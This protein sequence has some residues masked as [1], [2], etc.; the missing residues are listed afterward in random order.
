MIVRGAFNHLLRPGLRKDFRDEYQAYAEEY[1]RIL[2]TGS[3]DRAEIEAVTMAGLPRMTRRGEAEP[4]SYIDPVL[5]DK[6]IFVDDEFALGFSVS[7]RTMEDDLYSKAKQNAKWLGRSARLTQEYRCAD[8]LDD[9]FDGNLF[10]GLNGDSLIA[11]DHFLLNAAGT[12]SNRV[13]GDPQLSVTGLQAMFELGEKLVDQNGDPVVSQIDTL[14][15]NIQ[16]EWA[17]IHLTQSELEPY[18]ADNQ[19]NATRRK[20]QNLSY[21]V[22]HYKSQ[23]GRDWFGRDSNLHDAHFLFRVRPEFMDDFDFDTLQAKFIGRQRINVYFFDQ[24][25]WFGSNAA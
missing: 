15:I 8:L 14:V 9:A 16:D 18:T 17:A 4:V 23:D 3:Q 11:D 2:R 22:S 5:S 24:R 10:T 25:G 7:K 19:V 13:A 21:I 20:R 6:F 12:W 1:S